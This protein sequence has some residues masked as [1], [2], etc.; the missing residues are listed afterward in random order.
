M[1]VSALFFPQLPSCFPS[2]IVFLSP[3]ECCLLII[4]P[5]YNTLSLVIFSSNESSGSI[6]LVVHGVCEIP[7]HIFLQTHYG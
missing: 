4:Y 1:L 2:I 6:Q 5:Q 3:R 7:L